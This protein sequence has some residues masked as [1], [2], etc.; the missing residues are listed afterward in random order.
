MKKLS[1]I[2]FIISP[3][4]ISIL[5]LGAFVVDIEDWDIRKSWASMITFALI[6]LFFII[7]FVSLTYKVLKS[8]K[9][10]WKKY[11]LIIFYAIIFLLTI[12]LF[13]KERDLWIKITTVISL[14]VILLLFFIKGYKWKK[15]FLS[16]HTI[17]FSLISVIFFVVIIINNQK[18]HVSIDKQVLYESENGR[19]KIVLQGDGVWEKEYL[20]YF[21][22][23]IIRKRVKFEGQLGDGTWNVFNKKGNVVGIIAIKN[24][25]EISRKNILAE[26]TILVKTIDDIK[27]NI[28]KQDITFLFEGQY[29]FKDPIKLTNCKNL[30]FESIPS[31]IK[32]QITAENHP[33]FIILNS[34]NIDINDI[35]MH[36][37]NTSSMVDIYNSQNISILESLITGNSDKGIS[38]DEFSSDIKIS[39]NEFRNQKSFSIVA[40]STNT[41]IEENHFYVNDRYNKSKAVFLQDKHYDIQTGIDLF[42]NIILSY[43]GNW[44]NENNSN[45][46]TLFGKTYF[47]HNGTIGDLF[48]FFNAY[49]IIEDFIESNYCSNCGCSSPYCYNFLEMIS[50]YKLFI[51]SPTSEDDWCFYENDK[52]KFKFI[53]PEF[54]K[55][56]A[57]DLNLNPESL[58]QGVS[59]KTLFHTLFEDFI[60][61]YYLAYKALTDQ[62]QLPGLTTKYKDFNDSTNDYSELDLFLF[63]EYIDEIATDV[64]Y[65]FYH[66]TNSSFDKNDLG[67][68]YQDSD[69]NL[70]ETIVYTDKGSLTASDYSKIVSFWLRRSIDGSATIIYSTIVYYL[71][72][73]DKEWLKEVR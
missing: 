60:R 69:I 15:I 38:I 52:P 63:H 3:I 29:N 68:Y 6:A 9:T 43:N 16:I 20:V 42:E 73:Y 23:G 49:N 61:N 54:F 21:D 31:N 7:F 10:S 24:G 53:N 19:Q 28:Q 13:F 22:I 35:N 40:Y 25:I 26:N 2:T 65:I 72:I 34:S 45:N 30:K 32:T 5:I 57:H 48:I 18:D 12:P 17:L 33:C 58:I 39:N 4:I 14:V 37:T 71:K 11:S 47:K 66:D 36:G 59:Y 50:G 1:T 44:N 51:D 27:G 62:G 56:L 55:W 67:E 41:K 70:Y 46:V 64:D 8:S